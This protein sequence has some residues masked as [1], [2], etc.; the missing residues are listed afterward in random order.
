VFSSQQAA[1]PSRAKKFPGASNFRLVKQT[2]QKHTAFGRKTILILLERPA[3]RA[4]QKYESQA[5]RSAVYAYDRAREK[6]GASMTDRSV[7]LITH[8][9]GGCPVV[10]AGDRWTIS[11]REARCD[12][13][14]LC[15][16]GLASVY[17]KLAALL[18]TLP[19]ES[20]LPD[21]CLLCDESGCDTAFRMEHVQRKT[22]LPAADLPATHAPRT[23]RRL[24]RSDAHEPPTARKQG[25]FLTRL[26]RE[27]AAE[28][29]AACQSKNYADGQII[30]MQGAVGEHLFIVS[31]GHV[32]VARWGGAGDET[33]LVTLGTGDCFGEMSLLTGEATSAEVR[34]KGPSVVLSLHKEPFEALLEKQPGLAREFSKLLADRLKATNVSLES[35]LRRGV[36]GRLSMISLVDLVQTL[37]QSRQTGTLVLNYAGRQCRLGFRA[38][39]LCAGQS[40]D[41]LGEEAFY[42]TACWPDGDFCFEQQSAPDDTGPGRIKLDLMGLMMEGMRRIDEQKANQGLPP[43]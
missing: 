21:D 23:T 43:Q 36:Q 13:G 33:V 17:P 24:E 8:Q 15:A 26:S 19:P 34:S 42:N 37:H 14:R 20:D 3:V 22:S 16:A 39:A 28:L 18:N 5:K 29:V 25:P 40:G 32:D 11:G 35:E 38:G 30:L 10:K 31:E 41:L 4:F 1:T 2:R 6:Q 12:S 7:A 27:L 9:A